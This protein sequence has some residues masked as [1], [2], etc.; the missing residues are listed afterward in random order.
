[1][2]ASQRFGLI[3][4]WCVGP[5]CGGI[6]S[7]HRWSYIG[8]ITWFEE[9]G[10]RRGFHKFGEKYKRQGDRSY[11]GNIFRDILLYSSCFRSFKYNFVPRHCNRAANL[12]ANSARDSLSNT[13]LDQSP[14]FLDHVI[15]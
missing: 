5:L 1:M 3:V 2:V 13:W 15:S 10:I 8:F 4:R 11:N 9:G 6:G 7:S 12:L 14:D